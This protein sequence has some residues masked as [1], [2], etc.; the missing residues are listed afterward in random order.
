MLGFSSK[1]LIQV[2]QEGIG[3]HRY[4]V[5]DEDLD[6]ILPQCFELLGHFNCFDNIKEI[7]HG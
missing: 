6:L 7:Q 4:G 1:G 3:L 2:E 5:G